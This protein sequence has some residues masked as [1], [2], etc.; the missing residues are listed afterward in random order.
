EV[1]LEEVKDKSKAPPAPAAPM[2]DAAAAPKPEDKK[3]SG[4]KDVLPAT[5]PPPPG[6]G[7]PPAPAQGA[8]QP[9]DTKVPPPP[10]GANAGLPPKPEQDKA[11]QNKDGQAKPAQPQ[12]Q[13]VNEVP[14]DPFHKKYRN[15]FWELELWLLRKDGG[16]YGIKGK[17][18]NIG[19]R[20]QSL[21]I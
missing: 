21:G 17:I 1:P 19:K 15:P 18:T 2:P 8:A 3:Q 14:S 10:P 5:P 13:I 9:P 4:K 6:A 20:K 12:A 7:I 11:E 16:N